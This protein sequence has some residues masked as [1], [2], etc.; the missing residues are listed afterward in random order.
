MGTASF[1]HWAFRSGALDT[2]VGLCQREVPAILRSTLEPGDRVGSFDS[3][4]LGYFAPVP[5]V[6][7]D[8][9]VNADIVWLLLDARGVPW[10]DLYRSY[11]DE[12]GIDV[13]VGGTAFSW[14]NLFP[15][16]RSWPRLHDPLP[17]DDA[18]EVLLLRV[19]EVGR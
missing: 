8:G 3:G 1:F 16:L 9:L 10:A 14:V 17:T 6:N 2:Y 7:L 13:L 19:P 11:L 5:V 4:A 15:D 12:N 18:G